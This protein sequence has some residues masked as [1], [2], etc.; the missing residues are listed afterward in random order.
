MIIIDRSCCNEDIFLFCVLVGWSKDYRNEGFGEG[1]S[2][3]GQLISLI[4]AVQ[5]LLRSKSHLRKPLLKD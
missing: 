4:T 2:I 1:S 3:K 5:T